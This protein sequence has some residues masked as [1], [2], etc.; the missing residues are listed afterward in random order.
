MEINFSN[1]DVIFLYGHLQ[2]EIVALKKLKSTSGN[3]TISKVDINKEI[4][5]YSSLK[6]KLKEAC[7]PSQC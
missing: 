7:P 2:K 6:D 5:L 3:F 4:K 1:T